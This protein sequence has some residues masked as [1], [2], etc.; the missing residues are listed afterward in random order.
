MFRFNLLEHKVESKLE[1]VF[2]IPK[3]EEVEIPAEW[4][5]QVSVQTYSSYKGNP[6]YGYN[7]GNYKPGEIGQQSL[8][9]KR[10]MAK[11]EKEENRRYDFS[12]KN[13]DAHGAPRSLWEESMSEGEMNRR[14]Q[15]TQYDEL[16]NDIFSETGSGR[17][18]DTTGKVLSLDSRRSLPK[19]GE[20]ETNQASKA[21]GESSIS[22]DVETVQ[23]QSSVDMPG[24]YDYYEIQYGE[25]IAGAKEDIDVAIHDIKTCDEALV[26]T[27]RQCYEFLTE[28]GKSELMVNGL[29]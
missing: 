20:Q 3:P 14:F 19:A 23:G 6:G 12:K 13:R 9:S 21:N 18:I 29:R 22:T 24:E 8:A 4:L 25:L 15:A 10:D 28:E 26:D 17:I 27:I 11:A 1:D 16:D 2:E 5:D 7:P